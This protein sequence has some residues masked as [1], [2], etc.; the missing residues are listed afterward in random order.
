[1]FGARM[2]MNE[3]EIIWISMTGMSLL[4][5]ILVLFVKVDVDSIQKTSRI[6][7]MVSLFRYKWWKYT[8]AGV[9][10]CLSIL[11]FALYKGWIT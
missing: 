7:P 3:T 11:S 9:L 4:I 6:S 5:G 2:M 1:M 10:L 8:V